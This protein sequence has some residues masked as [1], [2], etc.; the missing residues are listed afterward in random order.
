MKLT[1]PVCL[2]VA[3]CGGPAK[4][5]T[6]PP[7]DPEVAPTDPVR[8]E[9][10]TSGPGCSFEIDPEAQVTWSVSAPEGTWSNNMMGWWL[11]AGDTKFNLF[12]VPPGSATEGEIQADMIARAE[13]VDGALVEQ[14]DAHV[15]LSMPDGTIGHVAVEGAE[16]RGIC[17]F[18]TTGDWRAAVAVCASLREDASA[19]PCPA[20]AS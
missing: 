1:I 14:T 12:W 8:E 3:A 11:E 16:G 9:I 18:D 20:P 2:L 5:A 10:A 6:T 7:P 15:V 13:E 17:E 19:P 4:P